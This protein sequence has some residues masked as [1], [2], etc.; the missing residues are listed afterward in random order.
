MTE[1]I[2]HET[3]R[4]R[5]MVQALLRLSRTRSSRLTIQPLEMPALIKEVVSGLQPKLVDCGGT[6]RY[7][8]IQKMKGDRALIQS[9]FQNLIENS[10]KY[11]REGVA[12]EVL[13]TSSATRDATQFVFRDNG[14]GIPG[15]EREQ[16]FEPF[17]QLTGGRTSKGLGLGLSV[18]KRI[19]MAHG[20]QISIDE[21]EGPGTCFVFTI[22]K[23]IAR[24]AE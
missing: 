10:V 11:R 14:S 2:A 16:V 8:G 20:G 12:P 5:A 19:V 7:E 6:V 13:I 24:L 23:Q 22:P 9:L 4:L 21:C 17:V 18:V 15:P 3:D 1:V